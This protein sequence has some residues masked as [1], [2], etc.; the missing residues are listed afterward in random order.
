MKTTNGS[1][2]LCKHFREC[3]PHID[4]NNIERY[5]LAGGIDFCKKYNE[6]NK[7]EIKWL[8]EEPS[9]DGKSGG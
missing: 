8:V 7:Y 1:C 2:F 9:Q 5:L 4:P 6:C 3:Y